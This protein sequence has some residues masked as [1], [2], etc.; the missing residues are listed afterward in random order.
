VNTGAFI[1]FLV[2]SEVCTYDKKILSSNNSGSG[3]GEEIVF[4]ITYQSFFLQQW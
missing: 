1:A 2:V 3:S 4:T